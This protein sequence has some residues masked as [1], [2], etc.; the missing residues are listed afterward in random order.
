MR[1]ES[2]PEPAAAALLDAAQLLAEHALAVADRDTA[3]TALTAMLEALYLLAHRAGRP[4][5]VLRLAGAHLHLATQLD[6]AAEVRRQLATARDLLDRLDAAG[7][8]HPV[9][10]QVRA[11]VEERLGALDG[12]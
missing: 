5:H 1:V 4:E 9:Q 11:E 7:L 12:S 8:S 3:V 10:A 6:D 2:D